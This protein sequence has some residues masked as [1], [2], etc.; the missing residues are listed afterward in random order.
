MTVDKALPTAPTMYLMR[1]A[2]VTLLKKYEKEKALIM[3]A[4]CDIL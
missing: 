3:N 1:L 4:L 2:R